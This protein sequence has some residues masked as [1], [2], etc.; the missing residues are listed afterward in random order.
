MITAGFLRGRMLIVVWTP[1][2]DHRH[3]FSMRKANER[4]QQFYG[5][6]I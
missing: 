5:K 3:V 1:R 6:K 2:G 4:E